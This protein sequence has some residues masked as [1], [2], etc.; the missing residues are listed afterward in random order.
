MKAATADVIVIGGGIAGL[1][2]TQRLAAAGLKVVVLEARERLGGRIFTQHHAG[3]PVELGA[4]FVHGRP[5]EILNAVQAAGLT[6]AEITGEFRSKIAGEWEDSGN[7]MAEVDELFDDIPE[8]GPDQ[9]FQQYMESTQYC[10]KVKQQA[11]RF[12]EGFHAADPVRVG[13]HWLVKATKAEESVDGDRSFRISAGYCKLVETLAN[14]I[15]GRSRIVLNTPVTAVRWRK[16][17]V[18]VITSQGEFRAPRAMITLPLG[19]LQADSV[20]FTPPLANKNEALRLLSMGPVIRVSLCFQNKFW[21]DDPH[22][23]DLSFLLTDNEHFPTWWT[24]NPLPYP[25][26][27][28]WAAGRYARALTGKSEAQ[29]TAIAVTALG[30][31]MGRSESDVKQMITTSFM[32]DWQTDP[33]ARGAYSYGNVGGANAARILAEPISDTLF[34]AGEA[35]NSEGHNGTVNGAISSGRRAADEILRGQSHTHRRDQKTP[36][37]R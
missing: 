25:I 15:G 24:S 32:H 29:L 2:A 12:V 10:A 13:I 20:E 33:F 6:L 9:S 5:P 26:L 30:Q 34:F 21:E 28:G 14:E 7:L 8:D 18:V 16:D 17:E 3:Y 35:T 37:G 1:A 36:F 11:A 23:R 27:T 4:E 19:V 22:M 31:V